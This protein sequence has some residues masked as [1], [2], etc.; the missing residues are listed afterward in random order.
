MNKGAS[1]QPSGSPFSLSRF[2]WDLIFMDYRGLSL[3]VL[4]KLNI[5]TNFCFLVTWRI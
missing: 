1:L 4:V 3:I 5:C 2:S